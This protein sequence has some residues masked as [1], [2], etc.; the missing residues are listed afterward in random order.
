MSPTQPPHHPPS[1]KPISSPEVDS[2]G[3]LIRPV[4]HDIYSISTASSSTDP[5]G[6]PTDSPIDF[7]ALALQHHAFAACLKKN[8]QLD[9]TD[10][11][12][13]RQ[14]TLALAK[15]NHALDLQLPTDRLCPPVPNRFGYI[16]FIQRLL[17]ASPALSFGEYLQPG[18]ESEREERGVLGIDVGTG[19]SAI[20]PLLALRQHS[21]WRMLATELDPTSL[22]YARENVKRN[23]LERRCR[24]L[25]AE[26]GFEPVASPP[27]NTD[28]TNS[29]G[30]RLKGPNLLPLKSLQEMAIR[31]VDFIMTNPPFYT[32]PTALLSSARA[33]NRPPNSA[34]TGTETEMVCEGGEVAWVERL[35]VESKFLHAQGRVSVRWTTSMLGHLASV[36]LVVGVLKREGCGDYVITEFVQGSKTR[37]WGL[38]WSWEGWRVGD[39]VGRDV[40]PGVER[41]LLPV[42]TRFEWEVELA[43]KSQGRGRRNEREEWREVGRWVD[44]VVEELDDAEEEEDGEDEADSLGLQRPGVRWRWDVKAQSGVGACTKGDCWS[45]KARRAREMQKR[46]RLR[47]ISDGVGDE[48]APMQDHDDDGGEGRAHLVEEKRKKMVFKITVSPWTGSSD[49]STSGTASTNANATGTVKIQIDWLFGHDPV[50]FESFCGWLRRKVRERVEKASSS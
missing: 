40:G 28:A 37:R 2:N 29:G 34:C 16:L 49:A 47:R 22:R 20:Y 30:G 3:A 38:G 7:R 43:G 17:D 45:R 18:P 48:D 15:I 6:K 13:V 14:L 8:G 4:P 1:T 12:S 25:E 11:E 35:I 33:K 9:F 50:L 27:R 26:G 42:S 24:V 44:E 5:T 23:G 46:S 10:P 31:E 39:E 32:S 19:A 36:A 21:S 41:G